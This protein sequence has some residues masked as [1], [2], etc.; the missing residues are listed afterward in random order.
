M[1]LLELARICCRVL[2]TALSFKE[3]RMMAECGIELGAACVSV[4]LVTA[5]ARACAS[6]FAGLKQR[7]TVLHRLVSTVESICKSASC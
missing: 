3:R 7:I 1:G 5:L 4:T 2:D 6:A